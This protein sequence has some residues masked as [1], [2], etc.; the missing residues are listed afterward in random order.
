[1]RVHEVVDGDGDLEGRRVRVREWVRD[2]RGRFDDDADDDNADDH[3]D[4]DD[5]DEDDD[6][7][8]DD[9]SDDDDVDDSDD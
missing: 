2:L 9:D 5:H 3:D 4:A 1:M 6:Y 8:D 7:V